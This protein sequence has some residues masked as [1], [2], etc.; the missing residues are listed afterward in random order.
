MRSRLCGLRALQQ[1]LRFWLPGRLRLPLPSSR[2]PQADGLPGD[3]G[4]LRP[5]LH[6]NVDLPALRQLRRRLR[7]NL[8]SRRGASRARSR[9]SGPGA[10]GPWVA[11]AAE[12]HRHGPVAVDYQYG[13][14]AFLDVEV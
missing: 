14:D 5:R 12:D 2:G 13:P 6:R 7:G 8:G 1:E 4:T 10:E 3:K 11:A 9:R